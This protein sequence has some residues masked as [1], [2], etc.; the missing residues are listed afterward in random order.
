MGENE[1]LDDELHV[2]DAAGVLFDVEFSRVRGTVGVEHLAAH[3]DDF[4]AQTGLG[5]ACA[6]DFRRTDSKR[7][8]TAGSPATKR[9]RVS[10][11]CSQTQAW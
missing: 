9:A 7:S 2:D 11:W 5:R 3:G 6:E 10:A 8:P 1:V 4:V